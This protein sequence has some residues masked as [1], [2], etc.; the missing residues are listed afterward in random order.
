MHGYNTLLSLWAS[1]W[2][3]VI[4]SVISYTKY[5]ALKRNI[6]DILHE[7]ICL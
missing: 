6:V 1:I 7:A 3:G 2:Q 4:Q 5:I